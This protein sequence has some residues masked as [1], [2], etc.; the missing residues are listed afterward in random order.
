MKP[1]DLLHTHIV[2]STETALLK[3]AGELD[4]ATAPLVD[5][6][7]ADCLACGVLRLNIDLAAVTFC[8]T[9]GLRALER[10]KRASAARC[11]VF[12]LAGM[13]R[14]LRRTFALHHASSLIAPA[15]T[16]LMRLR[17]ATQRTT[18]DR[19]GTSTHAWAS[20]ICPAP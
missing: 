14:Q 17:G 18:E 9:A 10:A 3:L 2:A 12:R 1:Q 15:M 7:V 8:D 5:Q 11:T 6:A 13:H 19:M 16:D 20:R 4:M